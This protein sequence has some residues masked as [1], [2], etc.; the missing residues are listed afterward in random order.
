MK[1]AVEFRSHLVFG[2]EILA[3]FATFL[4]VESARSAARGKMDRPEMRHLLGF[5]P[6]INFNPE[7]FDG[8]TAVAN[9][10]LR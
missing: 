3:G 7:K 10:G 4:P 1:T 9:G 2:W 6:V 5:L 8:G